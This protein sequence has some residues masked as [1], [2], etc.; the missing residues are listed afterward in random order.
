MCDTSHSRVRS[1]TGGRRIVTVAKTLS[2]SEQAL[3]NRVKAADQGGLT[4]AAMPAV[5][6]EPMEIR[7]LRAELAGVTVGAIS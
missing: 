5:S 2:L 1:V 3:H 6:A 4:G 7:R